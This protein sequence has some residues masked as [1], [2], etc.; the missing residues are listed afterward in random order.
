MTELLAAVPNATVT[1]A[2]MG[3]GWAQA[4]RA[5]LWPPRQLVT[6][7]RAKCRKASKVKIAE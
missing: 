4:V 6:S 1:D 2:P 5:S 3:E 7:R